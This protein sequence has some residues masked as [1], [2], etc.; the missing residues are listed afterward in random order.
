MGIY[1]Q[2]S[3]MY[4]YT[5]RVSMFAIAVSSMYKRLWSIQVYIYGDNMR[6]IWSRGAVM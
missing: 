3:Y 1:T 6:I 4:T 2:D 5:A